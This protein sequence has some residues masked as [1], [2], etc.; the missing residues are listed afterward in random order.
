MRI[1]DSRYDRD[2]L[3]F[4]VACR[5]IR[6]EART[7][8]IRQGTGLS[9]DRIRKLYRAYFAAEPGPRVRRRRGKSPRQM[10]FFARSVEH[11]VEAATLAALLR[12]CGLLAD[13]PTGRAGRLEDTARFCSAYE[14][15]RSLCPAAHVSFEHAWFLRQ[16]LAR[17]E[18]Y[19]AVPCPRCRGLWI[20]DRLALQDGHCAACRHPPL[21]LAVPGAPRRR[22]A[23]IAV[24]PLSRPAL[25]C[26]PPT[27]SP[28]RT[29]TEPPTCARTQDS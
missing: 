10:S 1:S 6:H 5:M 18:D 3:R 2:R 22:I 21:P 7:C 28:V 23:R 24:S 19:A 11:E 29:S 15:F 25:A 27:Y 14:T 13:R 9:D 20:R 12:L 26:D 4:E 17:H 16:V 8:T